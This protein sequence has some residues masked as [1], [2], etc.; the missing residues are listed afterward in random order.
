MRQNIMKPTH[1]QFT[2]YQQ[3]FDYFNAALFDNQ[4]PGVLLNFS[5][6]ANTHGF[7]APERWENGL[8]VKTHEISLNPQT[9]AREPKLVLSTLVHEMVH[10]WQQ[11][12]GTPSRRAYHNKQW[13]QKMESVGLI[14]SHTGEPGGNKTG[15]NMTHYIE[16]GGRFDKAFEAMPE[17][18]LLPF[19]SREYGMQGS[20]KTGAKTKDKSKLKYTCPVCAVNVWGKVGLYLKCGDCDQELEPEE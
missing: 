5:R 7:F 11:D 8:K 6:K 16:A 2:A 12:F 3:I 14:P 9:L 17:A 4:L 1:A 13:A 20:G 18:Y 19:T 15:Q 10:L